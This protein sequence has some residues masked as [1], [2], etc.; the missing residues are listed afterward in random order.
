MLSG[1]AASRA[2]YF[3]WSATQRGV[4]FRQGMGWGSL[5]LKGGHQTDFRTGYL[6]W[7]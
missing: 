7:A 3:G 5:G 2:A 6:A 1:H 4:G